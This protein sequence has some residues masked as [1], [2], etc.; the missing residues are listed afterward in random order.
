MLRG[1]PLADDGDCGI[2]GTGVV[3]LLTEEE[4]RF[5][6]REWIAQRIGKVLLSVF[7]LAGL[8]GLLGAGPLSSTTRQ[9]AD[10]LFSVE[11]NWVSRHQ[12]DETLTVT[13]SPE[14]VQNGTVTLELTGEW[15]AG[16][17]LQNISPEPAEQRALADGIALTFL[18]EPSAETA[19]SL[20]FTTAGHFAL[21]GRAAVGD[22]SVTFTQFVLP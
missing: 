12:E 1:S 3:G 22:D 20:S 2:E 15:L 7:V 8:A 11:V 6:R 17:D 9:S 19:V 16:A 21:R 18:V 14:A 13:F 4:R 10:G 5:P